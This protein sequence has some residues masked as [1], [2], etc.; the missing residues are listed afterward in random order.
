GELGHGV[1]RG[2]RR[3]P[4]Q[5]EET[6]PYLGNHHT[7]TGRRALRSSAGIFLATARPTLEP[8]GPPSSA[9]N[10]PDHFGF[11]RL[12]ARRRFEKGCG[13]EFGNGGSRIS[14]RARG[15]FS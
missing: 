7:G 4:R 9:A 13:A 15:G 8:P 6:S 14:A 12:D 2:P 5:P 11:Q 1:S 10:P 3:C